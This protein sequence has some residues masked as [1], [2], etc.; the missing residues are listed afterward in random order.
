M[1]MNKQTVVL[2]VLV[3]AATTQISSQ[4]VVFDLMNNCD[5]GMRTAIISYVFSKNTSTMFAHLS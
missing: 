5:P 2:Y 4:N 3:A 1:G